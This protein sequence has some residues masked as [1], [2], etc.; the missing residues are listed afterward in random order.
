MELD[1]SIFILALIAAGASVFFFLFIM[2][3][4]R[5]NSRWD[6]PK[7]NADDPNAVWKMLNQQ[8]TST[9]SPMQSQSSGA[10]ISLQDILQQMRSGSASSTATS[11]TATTSPYS[12]RMNTRKPGPGC[13]TLIGRVFFGLVLIGAGLGI[14]GYA[15]QRWNEF[16]AS[17]DWPQVQGEVTSATISESYDSEDNE[18]TYRP[19]VSYRY[20]VDGE[21]YESSSIDFRIFSKS[22]SS[23]SDA[24]AAMRGYSQGWPVTVTYN[25]D[26]PEKAVLKRELDETL[27]KVMMGGGLVAIILGITTILSTFLRFLASIFNPQRGEAYA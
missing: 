24:Q 4:S 25:P 23:R 18:Y 3:L 7:G 14:G 19:Q 21:Q 10:D 13:S 15:Y 16:N 2:T 26:N 22:Y 1:S 5:Q 6:M 20:M 12:V 8:G 27:A 11:S 17:E 9:K